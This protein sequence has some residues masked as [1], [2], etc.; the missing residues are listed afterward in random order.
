[1]TEGL[2]R[3]AVLVLVLAIVARVSGFLQ[4]H[5]LQ[6][7]SS[8]SSSVSSIVHSD[9]TRHSHHSLSMAITPDG[10]GRD[11]AAF[12]SSLI[13]QM[14]RS[15]R[16]EFSGYDMVDI[17]VEKWG[18]PHDIQIKKEVFAGKPLV[19][20]NVMWKYLGQ[21]SFHLSEREY[22]EHLEAIAQ[23]L[24]QWDRVEHFKGLVKASRKRPNAYFGYAVSIPL[25]L[26]MDT[27]LP[28]FPELD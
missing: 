26:P 5:L 28:M 12:R 20:L 25:E 7:Q 19:F 15:E 9:S 4:S 10:S 24:R 22:L 17:I 2:S 13:K 16:E 27:L 23:L 14:K 1:M 21:Q 8:F 6:P 3:A 18:V 11:M